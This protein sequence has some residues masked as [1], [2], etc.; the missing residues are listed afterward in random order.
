MSD[1]NRKKDIPDCMSGKAIEILE[2]PGE[3]DCVCGN[4]ERI[5]KAI[6]EGGGGGTGEVKSVNG[7]KGNV[8]LTGNDIKAGEE[9]DY[10]LSQVSSAVIENEENKTQLNRIKINDWLY[11]RDYDLLDYDYAISTINS[12][13]HNL[14]L[15]A[16][17]PFP[18]CSAVQAGEYFG[19]NLDWTY[20]EGVDFV[21]RTSGAG[22]RY[23]TIGVVG[24]VNAIN[25]HT[26]EADEIDYRTLPFYVSDGIN[27]T[28]LYVALNVVPS[29]DT[30]EDK[31]FAGRTTGTNPDGEE[32]CAIALP[33]LIL[34]NFSSPYEACEWLQSDEINIFCPGS[35]ASTN[36]LHFMIGNMSECYVVEFIQ[37]KVVVTNIGEHRY[38]TNYYVY[39]STFNA[40]GTVDYTTVTDH[41]QG[42]ARGNDI[43]E[44]LPKIQDYNAVKYGMNELLKYTH[45]YTSKDWLDELSGVYET[46]GDLT[47]KKAF[48][49]PQDYDKIHDAA[50]EMYKSRTRE[51]GENYGTWQTE[52][53]S[54][55]NLQSKT[56]NLVVQEDASQSFNF[57]MMSEDEYVKTYQGEE[58]KNKI[59][60]IDATG[61]VTPIEGASGDGIKEINGYRDEKVI[62]TS[63][64]IPIDRDSDTRILERLPYRVYLEEGGKVSGDT[65]A[66]DVVETE[67]YAF[68]GGAVCRLDRQKKDGNN[69]ILWDST[70]SNDP[71]KTSVTQYILNTNDLTWTSEKITK[72]YP[73][74]V[75]SYSAN[76]PMVWSSY[77]NGTGSMITAWTKP[78]ASNLPMDSSTTDKTV[79][80]E[81]ERLDNAISSIT[82]GV[83]EKVHNP[84]SWGLSQKQ[85]QNLFAAWK[86]GKRAYAYY[87]DVRTGRDEYEEYDLSYAFRRA[88]TIEEFERTITTL[89]FEY[90]DK[91]KTI[92][93][94]EMVGRDP[95]IF[96]DDAERVTSVNGK[97]GNIENVV[98]YHEYEIDSTS[99][100]FPMFNSSTYSE[101]LEYAKK[102]HTIILKIM[103]RSN[104]TARVLYNR[105]EEGGVD[106]LLVLMKSD[107]LAKA[108]MY[109]DRSTYTVL[110]SLLDIECPYSVVDDI[111]VPSLTTSN[112]YYIALANRHKAFI[113]IH[114]SGN[115]QC[116][117]N[118]LSANY[119]EGN[120]VVRVQIGDNKI[121]KFTY[122][123]T[124]VITTDIT[125]QTTSTEVLEDEIITEEDK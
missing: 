20:N 58:N 112:M 89:V 123:N 10:T 74:K 95:E 18:G 14:G 27:E 50:E 40:D 115:S 44:A 4:L 29:G 121:R 61:K 25:Q 16:T 52:H 87:E 68:Y 9:I 64:D 46:Y 124:R 13:Y 56:L 33:R 66:L 99:D 116:V 98:E 5:A 57:G 24:A 31:E 12:R 88:E 110:Y 75:A 6:E 69:I 47:V 107:S 119:E 3:P 8:V 97:T 117:F 100:G 114:L 38:M 73:T 55:Y 106:G 111:K 83:G 1:Y 23:A 26:A 36:E 81:I 32:V 76:F 22:K 65:R 37:N 82:F 60:G 7:M 35:P 59:L 94:D 51:Y 84:V 19:K 28:G 42:V 70:E 104:T 39:D 21:V 120:Y 11:S 49:T 71:E 72:Q 53:S 118:V 108:V 103:D 77:S 113:R 62:L 86:S 96:E 34:D 2:V 79:S 30:K 90:D 15:E 91:I 43:A 125:Y 85:I 122:D 63:K 92:S 78:T 17:K 67:F 45:T 48:E 80:T 54:I 101:I 102:G 93:L 41:S 105:T 109:S